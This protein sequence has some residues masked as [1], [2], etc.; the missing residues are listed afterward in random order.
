MRTSD[1]GNDGICFFVSLRPNFWP[2][3]QGIFKNR[4]WISPLNCGARENSTYGFPWYRC[5]LNP[6]KTLQIIYYLRLTFFLEERI[7][8]HLGILILCILC[9]W[10]SH[11][12]RFFIFFRT[13]LEFGCCF[14]R[15]CDGMVPQPDDR[16]LLMR[17]PLVLDKK[18]CHHQTIFCY[19]Y[20]IHTLWCQLPLFSAQH[21][22]LPRRDPGFSLFMAL[23]AMRSLSQYV[24][25]FVM[26]LT[27]TISY[28]FSVT[29]VNACSPTICPFHP[30]VS[31]CRTRWSAG[32][33]NGFLNHQVSNWF[34]LLI[35]YKYSHFKVIDP[36][37]TRLHLTLKQ[38]WR[39]PSHSRQQWYTDNRTRYRNRR[40]RPKA[41]WTI[42]T[43]SAIIFVWTSNLIPSEY[44]LLSWTKPF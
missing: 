44:L 38:V 35:Y 12:E 16:G 20:I 5:N 21:N 24:A 23:G 22:S 34:Y 41:R 28:R 2:E 40:L 29:D 4:D 13:S 19:Q 8:S 9:F 27:C 32:F 7:V 31:G 25:A 15:L 39:D 36:K 11:S 43:C 37:I 42:V 6:R 1:F 17:V 26:I 18:K 33:R 10:L 3:S 14:H 30:I